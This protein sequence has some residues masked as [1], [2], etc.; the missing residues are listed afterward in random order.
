[1]C[2]C[3]CTTLFYSVTNSWYVFSFDHVLR[4]MLAFYGFFFSE[5]PE[6]Q[7]TVQV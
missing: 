4:K 6:S 2:L 7:K 3:V 1:M 5:S